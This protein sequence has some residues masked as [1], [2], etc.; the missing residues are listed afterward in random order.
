[1]SGP[2]ESNKT[3]PV[4][5]DSTLR[6]IERATG[7]QVK[8]SGQTSKTRPP[9]KR[10]RSRWKRPVAIAGVCALGFGVPSA[11]IGVSVADARGPAHDIATAAVDASGGADLAAGLGWGLTNAKRK[12]NGERDSR[13]EQAERGDE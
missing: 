3:A 4:L 2:S 6:A 8:S 11:S 7:R 9:P 12:R 5:M 13:D 10:R 1:V